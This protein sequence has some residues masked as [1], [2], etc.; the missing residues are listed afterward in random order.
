MKKRISGMTAEKSHRL[1]MV[2]AKA[3]AKAFWDDL[4]PRRKERKEK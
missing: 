4:L 2:R 1:L 3:M